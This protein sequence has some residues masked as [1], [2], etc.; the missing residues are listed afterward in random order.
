MWLQKSREKWVVHGDKN[1][2]FFY[3]STIMRRQK[4]CKDMLKNDAGGWVTHGK[5]LENLAIEYFKRLYS[6]DEVEPEVE[7]LPREGFA[8]LSREDKVVLSRPFTGVEVESAMR[9]MGT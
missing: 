2:K 5:D 9:S 4:N 8:A 3:T 7:Q 6:L 1:T